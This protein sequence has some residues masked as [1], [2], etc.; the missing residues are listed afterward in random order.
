MRHIFISNPFRSGSAL[1]SRMLNAHSL[2]GMTVDKLKFFLFCYTRDTPLTL[3]SAERLV[4]DVVDR[5]SIRFKIQ[6][7]QTACLG[8]L[9]Q[10][11]LNYATLYTALTNELF[12]GQNKTIVG[13]MEVIAWRSIPDFLEMLP[14]GKALMIIRDLRD[15][16]VSFKKL[17][18][19]PGNDYLVA[20]FNCIDA[21][22]H[23]TEY[24]KRYPQQFYGL[25]F[26]RMKADPQGEM[27][28]VC[29][30]LEI[31]FEPNM[32]DPSRWK[33]DTGQPWENHKTSSFYDSNDHQIPVGRWRRRITPE[34]WFMC[35]WIGKKQMEALEIPC[36]GEPV[37]QETFNKAIEMLMSSPLL[38]ECYKHR[39]ET[40]KGVQRYPLDPKKPS[41]WQ[42]DP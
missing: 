21:M 33:G 3:Q 37:S 4:G 15:V 38:R 9:V 29:E 16:L 5:L 13:E 34:E 6:I 10:Q 28:K 18:F 39:C 40:G 26:E 8:Y 7:D 12:K 1:T 23:Y 17:T 41:N 14:N 30:F 19:A 36:E 35:E 2:V 32:V 22:D 31:D 24:Q 20:L 11:P 42:K 27:E 25:R